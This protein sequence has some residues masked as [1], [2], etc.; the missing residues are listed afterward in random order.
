M[1]VSEGHTYQDVCI[2]LNKVV[3]RFH[4]LISAFGSFEVCVTFFICLL[5]RKQITA[6]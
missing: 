6:L 2:G 3:K 4:H 1:K 5:H